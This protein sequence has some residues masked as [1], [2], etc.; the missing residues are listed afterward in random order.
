MV[1]DEEV[2]AMPFTTA[3]DVVMEAAT[4]TSI[5]RTNGLVPMVTFGLR[6]METVALAGPLM[7]TGVPELFRKVSSELTSV[8]FAAENVPWGRLPT[9][10]GSN[11]PDSCVSSM[12]LLVGTATVTAAPPPTG[13]SAR[14][15]RE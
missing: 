14:A 5:F 10:N 1:K 12:R 7:C 9:M 11:L 3:P 2:K 13:G 8:R 4:F 6:G 15:E